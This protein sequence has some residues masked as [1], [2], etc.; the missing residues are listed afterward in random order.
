MLERLAILLLVGVS[1]LL[2]ELDGKSQS[3]LL[4]F[5]DSMTFQNAVQYRLVLRAGR[6]Q[7]FDVFIRNTIMNFLAFLYTENISESVRFM[8]PKDSR[9]Y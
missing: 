1:V 3:R 2:V 7:R 6:W 8:N 5:L 9:N 4:G